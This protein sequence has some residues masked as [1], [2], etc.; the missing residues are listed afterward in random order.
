[1]LWW[2]LREEGYFIDFADPDL[3]IVFASYNAGGTTWELF[4][5]AGL[6]IPVG[7]RWSFFVEG[8]YRWA[9]AELNDDFSGFG[10]IDLSGIQLAGGFSWNF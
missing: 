8:R 3:P 6:D 10:T 2:G 7:Y 4:A 5:V 1:L 9:E